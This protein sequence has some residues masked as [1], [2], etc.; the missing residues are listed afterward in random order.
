[1]PP[2]LTLPSPEEAHDDPSPEWGWEGEPPS[3]TAEQS[4]MLDVVIGE[5]RTS[6]LFSGGV[7]ANTG[8]S[9][10]WRYLEGAQWN[11]EP[12]RGK[13]VSAFFLD[14][15]QWRRDED[16]DGLLARALS[17]ESEATSGKLFVRGSCHLNRPL[18]WLHLGRENNALDPDANVR[19]LVYTLVR[20]MIIKKRKKT[21]RVNTYQYQ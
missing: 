10:V 21:P 17:F 9:A 18:I 3:L 12:A 15:L 19:F 4:A 8:K 2:N 20:G 7:D 13:R 5:V 16:V 1:M 11:V 6:P 14:T